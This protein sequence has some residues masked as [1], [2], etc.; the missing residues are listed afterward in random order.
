M[1]AYAFLCE[2]AFS[3]TKKYLLDLTLGLIN[4]KSKVNLQNFLTLSGEPWFCVLGRV[5]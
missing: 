1:Q 4:L 3:P 2:N 5:I